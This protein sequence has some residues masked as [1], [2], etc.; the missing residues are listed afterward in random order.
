MAKLTWALSLEKKGSSLQA[1]FPTE[2]SDAL[3][4]K[5]GDELILSPLTLPVGSLP[6]RWAITLKRKAKKPV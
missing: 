3:K 1:A 5:A 4:M 2:L 6:M